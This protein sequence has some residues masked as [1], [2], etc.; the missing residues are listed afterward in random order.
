MAEN[1]ALLDWL[2]QR[3]W[4]L[5]ASLDADATAASVAL[6]LRELFSCG[7]TGLMDMGSVEHTEVMV[8][9]LARSGARALVGNT[10]MDRGPE[11]MARPLGWLRQETDKVKAACRGSVGYAWAPRF[12]LSCSDRLWDWVRSTRGGELLAT[13]CAETAAELDHPDVN[14]AGGNV[15]YLHQRGT[16]S[17]KTLLVHCVHLREG[18]IDLLA[19]T[20]TAVVHCP[21]ANLRLG[22]GIAEVP[23]LASR[24]V[25]VLV[26]SDGAACGNSLDLAD[27]CRLAAGLASLGPEGLRIRGPFWLSAATERAASSMGWERVGR[28]EKGWQADLALLEP[29]EHEWAELER[30]E[31]PVRYLL[32]LPWQAL[33]R[34]T[35]VGGQVVYDDGEFPTI[36]P[37]AADLSRIREDLWARARSISPSFGGSP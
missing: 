1:R 36:P 30:A 37:V 22:S 35:M 24:D 20:D 13:H 26:G 15:W 4:P 3:I 6:S 8:D 17:G 25:D 12:A 7:C 16:L 18:E 10:L 11:Y 32:E 28:V 29:R 5:E 2:R 33:N 19:S 27:A 31:D 23:E 34:L 21:W 14:A 9:M